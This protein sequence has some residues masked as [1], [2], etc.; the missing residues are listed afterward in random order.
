[1]A[2]LDELEMDHLEMG[3]DESDVEF[4]IEDEESLEIRKPENSSKRTTRSMAEHRLGSK[5]FNALLQEVC[6]ANKS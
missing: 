3:E 5:S 4:E 6:H 2:R 1:L